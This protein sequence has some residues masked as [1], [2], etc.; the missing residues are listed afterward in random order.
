MFSTTPSITSASRHLQRAA[1]SNQD[2]YELVQ[3]IHTAAVEFST[4]KQVVKPVA[5]Q[6]EEG[7]ETEIQIYRKAR[8]KWA[9][10]GAV[11]GAVVAAAVVLLWWNPAGW[12]AFGCGI[13]GLAGGGA[14]GTGAH[15]LWDAK[16]GEAFGKRDRA[17]ECK[18]SLARIFPVLTL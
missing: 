1:L 10:G 9:T 6:L 16:A 14:V 18:V 3:D 5:R 17:R 8:N 11:S 13:G 12:V 15:C 4:L 7:Y 2:L